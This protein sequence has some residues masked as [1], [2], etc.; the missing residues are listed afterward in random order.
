VVDPPTRWD[1][2]QT[3]SGPLALLAVSDVGPIGVDLEEVR[4]VA[5]RDAIARRMFA[6]EACQEIAE[7]KPDERDHAF[8]AHWTAFEARQK[9]TG[10]GLHGTR[11]DPAK[12]R[13]LHFAPAPGWIAALAHAADIEPA[14][15]WFDHVCKVG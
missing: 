9:A 3:D 1:F 8:L 10:E 5:R 4:P 13:I 11:A 12:W 15:A 2:N 6:A 7:A 14:V